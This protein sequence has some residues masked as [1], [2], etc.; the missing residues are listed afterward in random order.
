MGERGNNDTV[1]L[2]PRDGKSPGV[3]FTPGL[4][5]SIRRADYRISTI[6]LESLKL[7][8]LI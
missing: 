5:I 2:L 8:A 3:V 4:R 6:F 1:S 7:P